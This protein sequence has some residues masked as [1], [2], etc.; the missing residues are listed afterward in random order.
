MLKIFE[1]N[2]D[3]V[4][5][6]N[7]GGPMDSSLAAEDVEIQALSDTQWRVRDTR[8]PDDDVRGLLGFIEKITK[9][10]TVFEVMALSDGFEWFSFASMHEAVAHLAHYGS[11]TAEGHRVGDLTWIS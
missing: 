5:G 8:L 4:F 10:D 2:A 1:G 6:G 9:T 3:P 7:S 11:K